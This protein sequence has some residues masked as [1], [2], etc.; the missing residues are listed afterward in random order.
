MAMEFPSIQTQTTMLI[1]MM[2]LACLVLLVISTLAAFRSRTQARIID[3]LRQ[4][5]HQE[6]P[7]A[8]LPPSGTPDQQ[9]SP[10][11]QGGSSAPRCAG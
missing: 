10:E 1:V 2:G 7:D 11:S 9:T 5:L 3:Q 8:V 6:Q 4:Q